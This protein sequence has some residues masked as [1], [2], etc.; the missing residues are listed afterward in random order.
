MELK[1][2]TELVEKFRRGDREVL[3]DLYRGHV[4]EIRILLRDGFSFRSKGRGMRFSGYKEPFRLQEVLQESFIHAFR[5]K[6][7]LGYDP[8]QP[9]RP[10]LV[11]IV[12]NFVIDRV[13]RERL[14][15]S[16]FVSVGD[17]AAVGEGVDD[18]LDRI[19]PMRAEL[20]PEDE[21]FR[22]Q[23]TQTLGRFVEE[24]D[25]EDRTVLQQHLMGELTQ[26]EVAEVLGTDRNDVRKR[27]RMMRERLLRHLKREG[28]IGSL[29]PAEVLE[30]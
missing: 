13:R 1:G 2:N 12:R 6:A 18:A 27:I 16:L 11:T 20:S 21:V 4:D 22:G 9:Y 19:A 28:F 14:E 23:L 5:E 17:V 7:R 25:E 30:Q 8:G 15:A 29:D 24:L 10:Y 26:N 3:A